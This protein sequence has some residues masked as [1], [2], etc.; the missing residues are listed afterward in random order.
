[1]RW[2]PAGRGGSILEEEGVPFLL[3]AAVEVDADVLAATSPE[4]TADE[5]EASACVTAA[6][7]APSLAPL[8][9]DFLGAMFNVQAMLLLLLISGRKPMLCL[10]GRLQA[11]SR[12]YMRASKNAWMRRSKAG[13]TRDRACH[14]LNSHFCGSRSCSTSFNL[15][16]GSLP[17]TIYMNFFK[18]PTPPVLPAARARAVHPAIKAR[19]PSG[20]AGPKTLRIACP[21]FVKQRP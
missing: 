18:P 13:K 11:S 10:P 15:F 14:H 12:S 1:M 3:A 16:I 6:A 9:R 21:S 7:A 19:P 8:R 4:A 20:V 5:E 17:T 2:T